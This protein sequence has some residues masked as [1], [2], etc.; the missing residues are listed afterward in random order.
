MQKARMREAQTN[1]CRD[2]RDCRR[3]NTVSEYW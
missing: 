1:S 2:K 3:T